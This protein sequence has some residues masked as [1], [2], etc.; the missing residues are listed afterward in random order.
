MTTKKQTK[1]KKTL[2]T[3]GYLTVI[4]TPKQIEE[5]NKKSKALGMGKGP[6]VRMI[7][8]KHKDKE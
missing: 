1:K 2:N 4:F 8:L 6:Y 5:I 3:D 7:Y